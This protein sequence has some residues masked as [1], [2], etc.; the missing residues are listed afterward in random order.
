MQYLNDQQLGETL[1]WEL[2]TDTYSMACVIG[3]MGQI[4]SGKDT[5]TDYIVEK[6]KYKKYAF[7]TPGKNMLIALG[8]P[9]KSVFGTQEEKMEIME[10]FGV[11]GRHMMQTVL[12]H[13]RE[14]MGDIVP[15]IDL[16]PSG[17]IWL[18][19]F[20]VYVDN[21]E[22]KYKSPKVITSDVRFLDEANAV[23]DL[24]GVI[25]K[26]IRD[27]DTEEKVAQHVSETSGNEIVPDY[28]IDNNGTLDELYEK[29]DAI[30]EEINMFHKKRV[31]AFKKN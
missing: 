14:N 30:V 7:A 9:K 25:I 3:V 12:T 17:N 31:K 16:G 13:L 2:S 21:L 20:Q 27:T 11:S 19:A 4:G 26:V 10:G 6:Y 18:K 29:L 5:S 24:G 1:D 28:T 15:D 23:K 22:K 8:V